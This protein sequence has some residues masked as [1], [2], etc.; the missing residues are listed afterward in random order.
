MAVGLRAGR[1]PGGSLRWGEMPL[2]PCALL[3][4]LPAQVRPQPQLEGKNSPY[5][6]PQLGLGIC[7]HHHLGDI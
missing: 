3:W 7:G 4:P 6:H 5:L 2:L 1:A